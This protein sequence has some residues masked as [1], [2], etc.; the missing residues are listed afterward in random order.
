MRKEVVTETKTLEVP[1]Q[2]EE[3]VIERVPAGQAAGASGVGTAA[4]HG[5]RAAGLRPGEEI[6]IPVKAEKVHVQK[7][8]V[9]KEEVTVGKREVSGTE[10]VTGTV[11]K[12]ELRVEKEGDIE[13]RGNT[14]GKGRKRRKK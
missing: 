12:E 13:V 10:Q 11:R 5:V 2:R 14:S 1:V 8:V 9:V 4:A 3:V 6:R 7:E